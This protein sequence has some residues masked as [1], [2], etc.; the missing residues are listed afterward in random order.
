MAL[1]KPELGLRQL[2]FWRET[3]RDTNV[4]VNSSCE[5]GGIEEDLYK[6]AS[7]IL[8]YT[9]MNMPGRGGPPNRGFGKPGRGKRGGFTDGAGLSPNQNLDNQT[10][11]PPHDMN[12]RR[13]QRGSYRTPSTNRDARVVSPLDGVLPKMHD[14]M[15]KQCDVSSLNQLLEPID[16]DFS[17]ICKLNCTLYDMATGLTGVNDP[18]QNNNTPSRDQPQPTGAASAA[19]ASNPAPGT[20]E[21]GNQSVS[22]DELTMS[23][24][25][26]ELTKQHEHTLMHIDKH[27]G[28]I[29]FAPFKPRDQLLSDAVSKINVQGAALMEVTGLLAEMN[30]NKGGTHLKDRVDRIEKQLI[31]YSFILEGLER[32]DRYP[33]EL[34]VINVIRSHMGFDIQARDIDLAVRFGAMNKKPCAVLVMLVCRWM[35]RSIIVYKIRDFLP[36]EIVDI[37]HAANAE[38]VCDNIESCW[39]ARGGE[40]L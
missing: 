18:Y 9:L 35:K 39:P 6:T 33:L 10:G 40:F 13:R 11:K 32:D 34:L 19:P 12:Q 29:L 31:D 15:S 28:S 3:W 7:C 22:S 36:E 26:L 8:A 25:R 37:L 4:P 20:T 17:E 27:M 16:Q 24:L 21:L 30:S 5:F 1:S 38:K 23:N 14:M 2:I